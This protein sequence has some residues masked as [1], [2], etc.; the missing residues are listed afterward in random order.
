MVWQKQSEWYWPCSGCHVST[1]LVIL[2]GKANTNR[3]KTLTL[4]TSTQ[5]QT[6]QGST[7]KCI[8]IH[9]TQ[10]NRNTPPRPQR[11]ISYVCVGCLPKKNSDFMDLTSWIDI[12]SPCT[13]S[14]F[15][16]FVSWR[17]I[18]VGSTFPNNLCPCAFTVV[19][20]SIMLVHVVEQSVVLYLPSSDLLRQLD[21]LFIIQS[22][23]SLSS[24]STYFLSPF[25]LYCNLDFSSY[26][27]TFS[28][29]VYLC[30]IY[31]LW[32][33]WT[34]LLLFSPAM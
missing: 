19:L 17:V 16:G 26:L 32:Q 14:W 5:S 25:Q 31:F 6:P 3:N 27:M 11:A 29:Q 1:H 13:P 15:S 9:P 8:L 18:Y 30:L 23:C 2:S 22:F 24:L 28:F 12:T 10:T 20:Q 4:P 33:Y 34:Q 7:P 21:R